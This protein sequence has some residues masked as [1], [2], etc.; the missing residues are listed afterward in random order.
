MWILL[1]EYGVPVLSKKAF[2]FLKKKKKKDVDLYHRIRLK[3]DEIQKNPNSFVE[4]VNFKPYR[5]A[6]VGDYRIIFFISN[7]KKINSVDIA[8][9]RKIYKNINY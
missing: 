1:S 6:R 2:N 9:R 4:L 3:I 5:K 8:H 7:E